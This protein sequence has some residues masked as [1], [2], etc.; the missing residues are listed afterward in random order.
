MNVKQLY[1]TEVWDHQTSYDSMF[2]GKFTGV[3]A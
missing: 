1:I 2:F 3:M